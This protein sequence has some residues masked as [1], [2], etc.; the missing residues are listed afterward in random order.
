MMGVSAMGLVKPAP[1][2]ISTPKLS[3]RPSGVRVFTAHS[4]AT[5][6]MAVPHSSTWR[7]PRRATSQPASGM[8]AP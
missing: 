8:A 6:S 4:V 5:T 2:D 3:I 7:V 1:K